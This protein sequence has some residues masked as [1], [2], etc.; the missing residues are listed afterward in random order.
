MNV[1][2]ED[3]L[4][5]LETGTFLSSQDSFVDG[6]SKWTSFDPHLYDQNDYFDHINKRSS[7]WN[8]FDHSI[9]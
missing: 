3:Q 8:N 1:G 9:L 6:V 4:V 5:R 2:E 7:T